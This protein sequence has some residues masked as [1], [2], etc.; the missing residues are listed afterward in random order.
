MKAD[1]DTKSLLDVLRDLVSRLE[2]G[3][4]PYALCGGLALAVHAFPRA[5]M[6]IDILTEEKFLDDIKTLAA[7]VGFKMESGVLELCEGTVKIYRLYQTA[8]ADE[9]PLVL[10]VLLV[11]PPLRKVWE[12]KERLEWE[13]GFISVVSREGLIQMKSLRNSGQDQ[14]DIRKLKEL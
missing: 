11:T 10:D 12:A 5:T 4:V 2:Q 14:D 13:G 6:D 3:N 1:G 8:A 7:E 9:Y